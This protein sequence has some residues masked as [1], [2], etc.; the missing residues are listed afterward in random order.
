MCVCVC[1]LLILIMRCYV[2]Y[3]EYMIYDSENGMI[4][5]ELMVIIGCHKTLSLNIDLCKY[6]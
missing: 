5:I 2:G 3:Y 4:K 1:V 6:K